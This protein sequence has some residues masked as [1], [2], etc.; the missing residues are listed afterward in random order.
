MATPSGIA[1]LPLK[2]LRDTLAACATF[3]ALTGAANAAAALA[4]VHYVSTT[5]TT[6]PFAVVDW[7]RSASWTKDS[8]GSRNYMDQEG[9]LVL[10]LRASVSSSADADEG[11]EAVTFM[12]TVGAIVG[13][14]LVLAG[15]GGYLDIERVSHG[16]PERP[17][18]D[19]AKS[20][21]DFH[22]IVLTI[23]YRSHA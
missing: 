12:N 13:E 4:F 19:E 6:Y 10:L 22:Q 11:D 7:G 18:Y 16:M 9:E 21:G 23:G 5:S 3:Q 2:Y 17:T 1:S 8:G 15:Q 20:S 14:L